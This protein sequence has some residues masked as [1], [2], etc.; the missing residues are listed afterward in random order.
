[1]NEGIQKLCTTFERMQKRDKKKEEREN[2]RQHAVDF[3]K[4][5]KERCLKD[6]QHRM[7]SVDPNGAIF[8]KKHLKHIA[9]LNDHL[10][11]LT[12]EAVE[13]TLRVCKDLN[14]LL[15]QGRKYYRSGMVGSRIVVSLDLKG[16]ELSDDPDFIQILIEEDC[17]PFWCYRATVGTPEEEMRA[18]ADSIIMQ[19]N[20]APMYLA[21]R[22]AK[23]DD[24]EENDIK[25][26]AAFECFFED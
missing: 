9:E 13:E 6:W 21:E 14:G 20:E 11:A 24:D 23:I 2:D 15:A 19:D 26:C 1:M 16:S 8:K 12:K 22:F 4:H 3:H 25:L 10:M 7:D 17:I 18:K 5:L